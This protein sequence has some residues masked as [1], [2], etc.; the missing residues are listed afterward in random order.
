MALRERNPNV[1]PTQP[2]GAKSATIAP[3]KDSLSK[4]PSTNKILKLFRVRKNGERLE[5][6]FV[7]GEMLGKVRSLAGLSG[8]SITAGRL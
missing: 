4:A 2:L 5:N 6:E 7:Q 8:R 1:L 3:Q